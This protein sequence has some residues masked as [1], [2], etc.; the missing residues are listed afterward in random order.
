M[1]A[2][3]VL[4][5]EPAFASAIAS[6][7]SSSISTDSPWESEMEQAGMSLSQSLNCA[8]ENSMKLWQVSEARGCNVFREYSRRLCFIACLFAFATA[9]GFFLC[10]LPTEV[11][12]VD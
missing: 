3:I 10:S 9:V 2:D 6:S 11:S 1:T 5:K 4:Q 7:N 12:W 8:L